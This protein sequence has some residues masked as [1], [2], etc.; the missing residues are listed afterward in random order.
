MIMHFGGAAI[1]AVVKG[2]L[3]AL[4]GHLP[5]PTTSGKKARLSWLLE[6]ELV[7]QS[8]AWESVL[9]FEDKTAPRPEIRDVTKC[10]EHFQAA[11]EVTVEGAAV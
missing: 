10:S 11:G 8:R 3:M 9:A 1:K 5:S 4:E 6:K 2:A 7:K